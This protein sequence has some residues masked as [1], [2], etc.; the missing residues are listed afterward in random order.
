[1][2]ATY[3]FLALGVLAAL[4]LGCGPDASDA[5]SDAASA[6]TAKPKPAPETV[7][8]A[9]GGKMD[10]STPSGPPMSAPPQMIPGKGMASIRPRTSQPVDLSKD[11]DLPK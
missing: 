10:P 3:R 2:K 5:A 8:A 1:M 7:P 4:A 11:E 6:L 9:Y